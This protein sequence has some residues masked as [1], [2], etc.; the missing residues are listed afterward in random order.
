MFLK[1]YDEKGK[2]IEKTRVKSEVFGLEDNPELIRQVALSQSSNRRINIAHSKDKGEVSGGG[3]KPHKQKGTGRARAGS[4][5]SP[6]WK[7]G[8]VTFGPLNKRN[9]KKTVPKKMRRKALFGVL[10]AKAKKDLIFVLSNKLSFEEP[11]TKKASEI[12]KNLP[13]GKSKFILVL[14][15]LEKNLVKS[16]SNIP[17]GK[18][19][20]AKELNVLDMLSSK[21]L[22]MTKESIKVIEET[23]FEKREKVEK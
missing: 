14:P 17:N 18:T 15:S 4:I 6:L 9:F 5:R 7:G 13:I 1:T 2:E 10:S 8:G 22:I 3:K 20:Q 19:M 16:F 11:K 12:I 23:F 21:Y